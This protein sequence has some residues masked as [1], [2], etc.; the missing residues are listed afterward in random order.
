MED[1]RAEL[2]ECLDPSFHTPA[3][4]AFALFETDVPP[5]SLALKLGHPS[6]SIPLPAKRGRQGGSS[7]SSDAGSSSSGGVGVA[8]DHGLAPSSTRHTPKRSGKSRWG[9]ALLLR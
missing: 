9:P 6:A 3:E 5:P 1:L 4:M 2:L 7:S 8:V